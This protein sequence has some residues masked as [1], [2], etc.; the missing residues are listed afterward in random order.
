MS[1]GWDAPRWGA[2]RGP[3]FSRGLQLRVCGPLRGR[4]RVGQPSAR[5]ALAWPLR[6]VPRQS[7]S[8]GLSCGR[9]LSSGGWVGLS[10]GCRER[11]HTSHPG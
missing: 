7:N 10:K 1:G 9:Y 11:V 2:R 8:R 5:G 6:A 4:S 3:W